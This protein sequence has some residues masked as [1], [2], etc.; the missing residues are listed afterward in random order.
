MK[1]IE[2]KGG[3]YL[4]TSALKWQTE[5]RY[6]F[7]AGDLRTF[8]S[9]VALVEHTLVFQAPDDVRDHQVEALRAERKKAMADFTK[10]L[11]DID[12]RIA[13]LLAIEH[14]P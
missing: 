7:V 8:G 10:T 11:T 1:T 2:L 9:Y 6:A 14:A 4:D 13:Q 12:A 5:P 3:I